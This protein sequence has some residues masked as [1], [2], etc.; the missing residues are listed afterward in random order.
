MRPETEKNP[1][2]LA[3]DRGGLVLD[4][5]AGEQL[6]SAL[7]ECIAAT[8][9]QLTKARN[10]A[11]PAPF[12]ENPVAHAMATKFQQRA[13][14][15]RQSLIDSLDAHRASLV[16]ARD[17]VRDAMRRYADDQESRVAQLRRIPE[18]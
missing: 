7:D 5:G 6:L 4:W 11:R 8:E 18:G 10:L 1:T 12:G 13:E 2:E 15:G 14:G 16:D 3:P 17:A 9:G